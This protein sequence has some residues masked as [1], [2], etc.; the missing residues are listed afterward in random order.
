ML[1]H[2]DFFTIIKLF[3]DHKLT[4]FSARMHVLEIMSKFK[5]FADILSMLHEEYLS[6]NFSGKTL[7][8]AV[9]QNLKFHVSNKTSLIWNSKFLNEIKGTIMQIWKFIHCFVSI[10][11]QHSENFAFLIREILELFALEVCKC[12]KK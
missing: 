8:S 10:Q 4:C 2:I 6:H 5:Y 7:F 3:L 11:K 1:Q 12:L 9:N